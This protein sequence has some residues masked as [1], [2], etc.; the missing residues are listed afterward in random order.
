MR[1]NVSLLET[2]ETS[3]ET[4]CLTLRSGRVFIIP[5]AETTGDNNEIKEEE[6]ESENEEEK[7]KKQLIYV[8][9]VFPW[10]FQKTVFFSYCD[11]ILVLICS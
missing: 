6:E 5:W 8:E 10:G 3:T 2:L 9:L 11:R 1:R 4:T 7:G